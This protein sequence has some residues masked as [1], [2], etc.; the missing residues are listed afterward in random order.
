VTVIHKVCVSN[1]KDIGEDEL[2]HVDVPED[3]QFLSVAVQDSPFGSG[4]MLW[5]KTEGASNTEMKFAHIPTG[6]FLFELG[7]DDAD[8]EYIG[9]TQSPSGLVGHLHRVK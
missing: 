9:T 5:Y 2:I 6:V 8:C 3:A 1:T 7:L 4:V